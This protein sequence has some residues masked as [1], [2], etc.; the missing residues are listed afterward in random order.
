MDHGGG[1]RRL[2][3]ERAGD[4]AEV[5]GYAEAAGIPEDGQ[6]HSG[7]RGFT[8]AD[9]GRDLEHGRAGVPQRAMEALRPGH[10]PRRKPRPRTGIDLDRIDGCGARAGREPVQL[11][12]RQLARFHGPERTSG[13]RSARDLFRKRRQPALRDGERRIRPDRRS[14]HRPKRPAPERARDLGQE[15]CGI[16]SA[17]HGGS[18]I[19]LE[20]LQRGQR[21]QSG[22]GLHRE[23]ERDQLQHDRRIPVSAGE[24]P[25]GEAEVGR[26][27]E[28]A[29]SFF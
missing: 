27:A 24:R 25:E 17:D 13:R 15:P 23:P 12:R 5:G 2:P 19:M 3:P 7:Q 20:F 16:L 18:G 8:G 9:L 29:G 14:R 28:A 10:G 6:L 11:A 4:E 1:G 22:A 26:H 21:R